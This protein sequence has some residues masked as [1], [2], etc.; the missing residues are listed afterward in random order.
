MLVDNACVFGSSKA[1]ECGVDAFIKD[2][3]QYALMADFLESLGVSVRWQRALDIGGAEATI[4]RLLR[5]QGLAKHT[6][7]IEIDDFSRSLSTLQFFRHYMKFRAA[8]FLAKMSRSVRNFLVDGQPWRGKRLSRYSHDFGWIPPRGSRFWR[9]SLRS[10]PEVD[11]YRIG[12]VYDLKDQFD[13][14]TAFSCIKWFDVDRLFAKVASLLVPG[15]TFFFLADYWWF[16][17]NS[18]FIVGHFP[19]VCQRLNEED[20]ERYVRNFHSSEREDFLA[21]YRSF[22]QGNLRPTLDDYVQAAHRAGL[23]MIGTRCLV[24]PRIEYGEPLPTPRFMNRQDVS[25]MDDVLADIRCFRS[26]VSRTD[27]TTSWVMGAFV[28]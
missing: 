25:A 9:L 5:G 16:P 27:L 24:P 10:A 12:D 21:R 8:T 15:G 26:D 7:T 6:T 13:L 18:T 11:D 2:V 14:I 4:A 23:R 19:Y 17:V 28:K 1:I 22:H 3:Y 20:F